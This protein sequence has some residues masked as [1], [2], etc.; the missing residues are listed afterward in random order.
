MTRVLV[1]LCMVALPAG[2]ASADITKYLYEL[3][4]PGAYPGEPKDPTV[5]TSLTINGAFFIS[6]DKQSTGTGVLQPFLKTTSNDQ[7]ESGYNTDAKK[8]LDN[9][10]SWTRSVRLGDLSDVT[11]PEGVRSKLFLLDF[12]HKGTQSEFTFMQLTD[13]QIFVGNG[14]AS[15]DTGDIW[16]APASA[17][18]V[19]DMDAGVDGDVRVQMDY[20]LDPGS[21]AGDMLVYIPSSLFEGI[22]GT[23][24]DTNMLLYSKYDHNND[25]P[26]EWN[27]ASSTLPPVPLPGAV[28]LGMLGM[29]AAGWRLRRFA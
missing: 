25:G 5:G 7:V 26:E 13:F 10:D 21:G 6:T 8:V 3:A 20:R 11:S 17:T 9:M 19:Y 22:P 12:D 29:G 28:I 4:V 24:A 16:V 27:V 14:L 15:Y 1:C 2:Q 23:N 18:L